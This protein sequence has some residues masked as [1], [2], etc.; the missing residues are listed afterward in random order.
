MAFNLKLGDNAVAIIVCAIL[1]LLAL[2]F[3][4]VVFVTDLKERRAK[5][6]KARNYERSLQRVQRRKKGPN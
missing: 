3:F 6:R 2:T 4:A 1:G 5:K